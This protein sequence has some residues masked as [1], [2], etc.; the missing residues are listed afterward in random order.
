MTFKPG[1]FIP[2]FFSG[3][4]VSGQDLI[5][6][7]VATQGENV[8]IKY[9]LMDDNIDHKYTLS[10]YASS[11][12]YIQPLELVSGDIG[13]DVAV[14]GSKK[15]IWNA[16]EELGTDFKGKVALEL[17]GKIYIPFVQLT[18]FESLDS[19]KRGRPYNLTWVAG[20]GNDVL[21]MDLYNKDKEIVHTFTNVA[22]VGEYELVI[23]KDIKPGKDYKMRIRDQK[24]SEDVVYTPTFSVKRKI[25]FLLQAAVGS[26]LV[27][28]GYVILANTGGGE[29]GSSEPDLFPDPVLPTN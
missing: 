4:I 27:G 19:F 24:N 28:T 3:L 15:V 13:V 8:I 17:K 20:R 11:D 9:E 23:P 18:D 6:S 7:S 14:G 1:L 22:N 16:K 26:A 29:F 25:P 21:T 10:L 12:N 5:I 2:I